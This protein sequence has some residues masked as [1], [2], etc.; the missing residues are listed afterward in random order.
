MSIDSPS[1]ETD[2]AALEA[3][4]VAL[5]ETLPVRAIVTLLHAWQVRLVDR[6]C[7]PSGEP[8]RG[9]PAPF[10]CTRCDAA[11]DFARKGRRNR[12]RRLD[13]TIGTVKFRL[14]QVRCRDCDK[15]FAPLLGML[16]L[17]W[18]R[19]S[20]RLTVDL[21]ET[22]TQMS[23]GRTAQVHD[24]LTPATPTAGQAH[25]SV[26]DIAAMLSDLAPVDVA[27]RVV[28]LDGTGVRAGER[29]L[30]VGAHLA[31]GL[32]GRTGPLS[33]RRAHTDLLAV[34]VGEGW[35]T[36]ADRLAGV[37]APELV[38]IDGEDAITTL[39]QRLWP[40]TPVQRCWWHLPRG[41]VKAGYADPGRPH[42][43]WVRSMADIL[44]GLP[45]RALTEEWTRSD[46]DAAFAEFTDRVPAR[47]TALH[48]YL[49]AAAPHAMTFCDPRLQRRLA[50]LG[51]V[52]LG[53]G[54]IE[55]PMRELNARTDIGGTRWSE[56]G[57]RDLLTVLT[58]RLFRH[59]AWTDLTHHLRPANTIGFDL[60]VA[61]VNG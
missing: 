32:S 51:G 4:G 17:I 37:A 8:V 60:R 52:E 39:S 34:T 26:A 3:L 13:T 48:A 25:A 24:R 14:W 15:V 61:Q 44:A 2:W 27:P 21:A 30:G 20:D 57:L 40:D 56:A 46:G 50:D 42:I 6:V 22:S 58:A 55:R 54:V 12:L 5:A 41:L 10:A 18:K 35:E 16:G 53:T 7:G 23:Y 9:L 19:R 29:R 43:P 36:M 28:L 11:E 47:Y 1:D 59:P 31:I 45:A 49:A 38:V 33:R